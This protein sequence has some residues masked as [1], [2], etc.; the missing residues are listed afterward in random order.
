MSLG[1]VAEASAASADAFAAAA[2]FAARSRVRFS[3]SFMTA[4][5]RF[6][7]SSAS[8]RSEES[9]NMYAGS[10]Y[11]RGGRTCFTL[12]EVVVNLRQ[13]HLDRV[14]QRDGLLL[15][16]PTTRRGSGGRCGAFQ[17]LGGLFFGRFGRGLLVVRRLPFQLSHVLAE[18]KELVHE[19]L[20]GASD[21]VLHLKTSQ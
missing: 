17:T 11:R 12:N 4:S 8:R 20:H 19:W 18:R 3:S 7:S 9:T 15:A 10:V 1:G 16:L 5:C 13:V 6:C 21:G 2:A 14:W